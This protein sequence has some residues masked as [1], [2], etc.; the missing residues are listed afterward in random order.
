M[1]WCCHAHTINAPTP[2]NQQ[3][4]GPRILSVHLWHMKGLY[5]LEWHVMQY[6]GCMTSVQENPMS[7]FMLTAWRIWR[8]KLAFKRQASE[9]IPKHNWETLNSHL[10]PWDRKRPRL[11][12]RRTSSKRFAA[13]KIPGI[14]YAM[15]HFPSIRALL[16][17]RQEYTHWIREWMYFECQH[18]ISHTPPVSSNSGEIALLESAW[19]TAQDRHQQSTKSSTFKL[20]NL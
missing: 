6:S 5:T 18:H 4:E 14:I 15:T 10:F 20:L 17:T 12:L 13:L 1:W 7:C 19:F 11:L 2:L 16:L 9:K 8:F 3:V